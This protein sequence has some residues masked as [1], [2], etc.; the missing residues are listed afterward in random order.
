MDTARQDAHD[1]V[2]SG[3]ERLNLRR[4]VRVE[5]LGNEAV[6]LD[7]AGDALHRVD[8]SALAALRLLQQGVDRRDIPAE[9]TDAVSALAD[10]GLVDGSP[11]ISRRAALTAGGGIAVTAAT[12]STFALAD[13]AAATTKCANGFVT[14]SLQ[15]FTAT[16]SAAMFRTGPGGT[17][18]TVSVIF[19]AWGGG[20]GGGKGWP[21]LDTSGGGGGAGAYAF[22]TVDLAE[23][24][25]HTL[26]VTV[27]AGGIGGSWSGG[28]DFGTASSVWVG[29]SLIV[30]A[31]GGRDGHNS[32]M[33]VH[34]L[35]G[36]GGIGFAGS[37]L[38]TGGSGAA[39]SSSG[40]GGGGGSA[41]HGG[42]GG[43][44][45]GTTGG[46]AGAGSPPGAAGGDGGGPD[47]A[48]MAGTVPGG[49]GGGGGRTTTTTTSN[50][51]NA[52]RGEVWIGG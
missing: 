39:G 25:D 47:T 14:D 43:S 17:G 40:G 30:Y 48:G 21:E 41:G 49:G 18:S 28:P 46:A 4:D 35:G 36:V 22:A 42:D 29:M 10:A 45:S 32:G 3:A 44:G 20:G 34:G 50:G 24:S 16:D 13:P 26:N 37:V 9:L 6:V 19:R 5:D 38:E 15:V 1:E 31:D 52:A 27:G 12:V 11:R 7:A 2:P 33:G 8:G 51:G 23:C